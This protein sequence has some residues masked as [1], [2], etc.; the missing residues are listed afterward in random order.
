[1]SDQNQQTPAGLPSDADLFRHAMAPEPAPSPQP[2]EQAP[3]SAEQPAGEREQPRD[4]RGRFAAIEQAPDAP[5]AATQQQ[6][7]QQ[8]P[9][10][11]P[12]QQ[13]PATEGDHDV[14]SWR[15][16]ELRQELQQERDRAR[17]I[18]AAYLDMQRQL[19]TLRQQQQ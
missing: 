15:H 18:E 14:P 4:E 5:A 3:A 2:T 11:Q 6:P 19:Q 9:P 8:Q 17:Q 7:A 16:R 13:Q 1:M 12:G 10:Q